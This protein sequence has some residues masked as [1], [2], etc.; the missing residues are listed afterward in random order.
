MHAKIK[1]G[2][3]SA[4]YLANLLVWDGNHPAVWPF[5]D[6]KLAL[7]LCANASAA[8][9]SMMVAG[10]WIGVEPTGEK[11]LPSFHGYL[12]RSKAYEWHQA[13]ARSRLNS[14]L[15]RAGISK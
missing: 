12:L 11:G 3:I 8:I 5:G 1:C 6:P 2:A 14:L 15:H 9:S 4:G 7:V 10:K 13:E